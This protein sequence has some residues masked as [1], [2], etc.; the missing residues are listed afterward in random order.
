MIVFNHDTSWQPSLAD[1]QEMTITSTSASQ[2]HV[3]NFEGM[4]FVNEKLLHVAMEKSGGSS[5]ILGFF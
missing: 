3:Q 1:R 4:E 5:W 2:N